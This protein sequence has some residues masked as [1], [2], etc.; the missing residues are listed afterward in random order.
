M[1]GATYEQLMTSLTASEDGVTPEVNIQQLLLESMN[2]AD[3]RVKAV[4]TY[5]LRRQAEADEQ[6]FE[7]RERLAAEES[8]GDEVGADGLR[9]RESYKHLRRVATVMYAEL[10]E[11]RARN[12]AL[13]GALGAC[14]LCWGEDG[15]CEVCHGQGQPGAFSP[16]R[17]L[18]E[19]Y[20][21]PTV[22]ILKTK[23]RMQPGRKEDRLNG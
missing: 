1:D 13:A 19:Q 15:E 3:P 5:L 18:F 20:V 7:A 6:K 12:D 22:R 16:D 14:Y 17:E 9:R 21:L 8:G 4:A 10:E 2:D 23:P 11:L